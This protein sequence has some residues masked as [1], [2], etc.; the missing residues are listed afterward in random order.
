M[1][2]RDLRYLNLLFEEA[3]DTDPVGGAKI[4]AALVF[5]KTLVIIG[6]NSKRT[7]PWALRFAKNN[8]ADTIHAEVQ[9]IKNAVNH[10]RGESNAKEFIKNATLYICRAKRKS[11]YGPWIWGLAFPCSGCMEAIKDFGIKRVV[12]SE[13]GIGNYG[14]IKRNLNF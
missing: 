10:F 8:D 4:C 2:K 12:Y 5:K 13:E 11:K 7:D 9:A 3:I 14:E 6:T 1:K